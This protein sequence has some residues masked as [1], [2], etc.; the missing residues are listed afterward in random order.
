MFVKIEGVELLQDKTNSQETEECKKIVLFVSRIQW[1][2]SF[3]LDISPEKQNN[4]PKIANITDRAQKLKA[5]RLQKN[6][7]AINQIQKQKSP[8]IVAVPVG[9]WVEKK[10]RVQASRIDF[11]QTPVRNA[12]MNERVMK[13]STIKD[14]IAKS[15]V[16]KENVMIFGKNIEKTQPSRSKKR[17]L[18]ELNAVVQSSN[19]QLM[20]DISKLND[21]FEI[22]PALED[23]IIDDPPKR[24]RRSNSLPEIVHKVKFVGPSKSSTKAATLKAVKKPAVKA[25]PLRK[26]LLSSKSVVSKSSSAVTARAALHADKPVIRKNVV[27][28]I[29]KPVRVPKHLKLNERKDEEIIAELEDIVEQ[30]KAPKPIAKQKNSQTFELY[31]S[32]LD[33]QL[34]YLKLQ[35][36]EIESEKKKFFES[37]EDDQQMSIQMTIQQGNL[38]MS[39]KLK[40]FAEF[41]DQYEADRSQPENP[42][43]LSKEDID[44]YWF[45]LYEEIDETKKSL[46]DIRV[47]KKKSNEKKRRSRRAYLPEEGT[48]KRS[49]RIADTPK[50]YL[51]YF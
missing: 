20:T 12:L 31:K 26:P 4:P 17:I 24:L 41:L 8:F 29:A 23:E 2:F 45:L 32:M 11:S 7:Q 5:Y 30:V 35:L 42:K 36:D 49:K 22:L 47:L 46:D 25:V 9:R 21:T 51:N 38:L 18:G 43:K 28:K 6:T 1:K 19:D 40:K 33:T 48:P 16:K 37:L 34:A 14:L 13:K 44:N 15:T 27:A 50:Y 10:E 39:E 3:R